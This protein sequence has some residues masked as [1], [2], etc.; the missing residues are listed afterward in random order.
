MRAADIAE[1]L[2]APIAGAAE[3]TRYALAKQ[4]GSMAATIDTNYGP[5]RLTPDEAV[6]LE[7][8]TRCL[9]ERRLATLE[10]HR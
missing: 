7:A 2:G 8:F 3:E 1:E 10:A 9:L 4:V 6:E 5:L